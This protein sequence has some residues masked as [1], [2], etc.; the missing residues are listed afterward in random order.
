MSVYNSER[1]LR[2]AVESILNQTFTDFE[3]IIVN[4]GSTDGTQEILESYRDERIILLNQENTGLTKA[5]NIG[6]AVTKGKYIARQDADDVSKLE[7]L[8]KQ[9]AFMETNPE[10]GLL[11]TRFQCIDHHGHVTRQAELQTE[12]K[13]LQ[14]RLAVINHF[15]HGSVMIRRDALDKVGL[16]REYFK[17]AQ[18]YDLWLR[19][20]EQYEVSNLPEYL[21]CY[22]ELEDAISSDKILVQSLYAGIAAEMALQ[23]R[24]TGTDTL[25]DGKVPERPHV[26]RLSNYLQ[27]KLLDFYCRNPHKMLDGFGINSNANSD[28]TYLFERICSDNQTYQAELR[29]SNTVK[30]YFQEE[31]LQKQKVFEEKDRIIAENFDKITQLRLSLQE[32]NQQI[33]LLKE[34]IS[35]SEQQLHHADQSF[36]ELQAQMITKAEELTYLTEELDRVKREKLAESRNYNQSISNKDQQINALADGLCQKEQRI[37]DLMNSKSW[38]I[39]APLRKILEIFQRT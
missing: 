4:D 36:R 1:F 11:G 8:E 12:N 25:L 27:E 31:L 10:V 5:L 15:C 33:P 34:Q 37:A 26:K 22:R 3:F 2:E 30:D 29:N 14:N 17:Y 35:F 7:R 38:K 23:R 13:W 32:L 20:A 16:F 19:I 24:E 21:F 6:I 28:L 18:D 9:V 39:T